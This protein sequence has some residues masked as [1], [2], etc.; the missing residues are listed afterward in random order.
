[1]THFARRIQAWPTT[2]NPVWNIGQIRSALL[3]HREGDFG[4]SSQLFDTLWEDDELPGDIQ[5]RV[6]AT[7]RASFRMEIEGDDRDLTDTEKEVQ[8]LFPQMAPDDQLFDLIKDWLVIGVGVGTLDWKITP[9]RWLPTLRVLPTEFLSYRVHEQEW[10]YQTRDGE[11]IVTPGDGKWVLMTSGER[12]WIKGL[13]RPLSLM[14]Y[15]KALAQGDWQ[16]YSQKHGLPII[17][18]KTPVFAD[19]AEKE[20]FIDALGD[21]QSEGVIGLPQGSKEEPGYDVEL[22][23]ATDQSWEGFMKFIERVDRK[24]QVML[25]GGNLGTEVATTGANRAA[26]EVQQL[27]LDREKAIPDANAT[28]ATTKDQIVG[29][30]M[31]INHGEGA[32]VPKPVWDV[33]PAEDVRGWVAAQT[34]YME[35]LNRAQTSGFKVDNAQQLGKKYGL[36]LSPAPLPVPATS[37]GSVPVKKTTK[38]QPR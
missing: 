15:S 22:M 25:L 17:K 8:K 7:L 16:R 2:T 6:N 19:A 35:M 18:A 26:A 37:A 1:M 4:P 27:N 32:E 34:Q 12:G 14:W 36:A 9:D 31:R 23:E 11:E 38:T 30:F 10:V 13:I 29:P 21:L 24:F 28:S 5:K 20:D 3:T 33:A